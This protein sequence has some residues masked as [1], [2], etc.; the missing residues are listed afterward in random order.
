[1]P[2][3]RAGF[4]RA[5]VAALL[6]LTAFLAAPRSGAAQSLDLDQNGRLDPWA[7]V[8]F[9]F[10]CVEQIS[11]AVPTAYRAQA[12]LRTD[13]VICEQVAAVGSRLDLDGRDGVGGETD[14]YYLARHLLGLP[15]VPPSERATNPGLPSDAA[16]ADA[17]D[18][19]RPGDEPPTATPS[20]TPT[21]TATST[22]TNT[23]TPSASATATETASYTPTRT[24]TPTATRTEVA[25]QTNTATRT[26][27]AT[28]THTG[29]LTPTP[30]PTISRSPTRTATPTR[31]VRPTRTPKNSSGQKSEQKPPAPWLH[32]PGDTQGLEDEDY[33]LEP[34]D[35]P[36]GLTA[37]SLVAGVPCALSE[38]CAVVGGISRLRTTFDSCDLARG[39]VTK[40]V[41]GI[42]TV[43]APGSAL[44]DTGNVPDGIELTRRLQD[45]RS[46]TL[47]GGSAIFEADD[48]MI[49]RTR[50]PEA[51]RSV[52][53]LNGDVAL[54]DSLTGRTTQL[55]FEDFVAVIVAHADGRRS[56]TIDGHVEVDCAGM[57][58]VRT[59]DILQFAAGAA[60][61]TGGEFRVAELAAL[62]EG[63]TS[64]TAGQDPVAAPLEAGTGPVAEYSTGISMQ[65]FRAEG[66]PV[67]QV[68]RFTGGS[69]G[70]DAAR[71]TSLVGSTGAV[72][73]CTDLP[74][75]IRVGALTIG[76]SEL[77]VPLDQ[78]TRSTIINDASP[79]RCFNP[80]AADGDGRL[81]LGPDCVTDSDC[82]CPP[83]GACRTFTLRDGGAMTVGDPVLP[84]GAERIP[85]AVAVQ[86][87]AN[88]TCSG[89][90]GWT[91]AFPFSGNGPTL[92]LDQ[93]DD[94]PEDGFTLALQDS[95]YATGVDGSTVV[96]AYDVGLAQFKAAV[97]ALGI[98]TDD[99]AGTLG[100]SCNRKVL[101]GESDPGAIAAPLVR[102][103]AAGV[104]YDLDDNG[105]D[106]IIPFA[107]LAGLPDGCE[108]DPTPAPEGPCPEPTP[109]GSGT[110]ISRTGT[111]TGGASRVG[112][113]KCGDGGR[114]APE[115]TFTY[116]PP[117]TGFYEINTTGSSFDTILSVRHGGCR[118]SEIACSDDRV[119][120]ALQS[121]IS[122][123]LEAGRTYT[124]IVDGYGE[125]EGNVVLNVRSLAA[126]PT[127]I[128]TPTA[129]P[130]L[131]DLI[132]ASANVSPEPAQLGNAVTTTVTVHNIGGS[133][134]GPSVAVVVLRNAGFGLELSG[135]CGLAAIP[136]GGTASCSVAFGVPPGAPVGAYQFEVTADGFAEVGESNEANNILGR[137][138]GVQPAPGA[139]VPTPVCPSAVLSESAVSG[140]TVGQ[141]N[142]VGGAS[143]GGFGNGGSF[144]P[145]RSFQYTAPAG[146]EYTFDTLGSAFD[147]LLYVREACAGAD[148]VCSDD[149][150]APGGGYVAQSQVTLT[151]QAGQTVVVVV[152]GYGGSQGNFTLNVRA[153]LRSACT[154]DCDGDGEVEGFEYGICQQI[155][156]LIPPGL[157]ASACPS[158]DA[159]GDGGVS[160]AEASEALQN[161]EGGCP[162][163][164]PVVMLDSPL[165]VDTSGLAGAE[166]DNLRAS[167]R[168]FGRPVIRF[169]DVSAAG[170]RAALAGRKALLIPEL[171]FGNLAAALSADALTV[172]RDF[173]RAGG[174][175]LVHGSSPGGVELLNLILGD[176]LGQPI[177]HV[178]A[179][180]FSDRLPAAAQT[181]CS[182]AP[183]SSPLPIFSNNATTALQDLPGNGRAL[184]GG[185]EAATVALIPYGGGQVGFLGWDWYDAAPVGSQDGGWLEVLGC[186][187]DE[188]TS[189]APIAIFDDGRFV[190]SSDTVGAE[191][192]NLQRSLADRGWRAS[193][194]TGIS[195]AQLQ[196]GLAGRQVL[197]IPELEQPTGNLDVELTE[198]AAQVLRDFI[199][200]GGGLI[201]HGY[202]QPRASRLLNRLFPWAV[203]EIAEYA[204]TQRTADGAALCPSP[205]GP[206][207]L[208]RND[209]TGYLATTSLPDGA[210]SLY[211]AS[212]PSGSVASVA[213]MPYGDGRVAFVGWDWFAAAPVGEQD[214][215][216]R[217][218]MDCVLR[219]VGPDQA[220]CADETLALPSSTAGS[221]AGRPDA[222]QG[223]FGYGA[224]DVTYRFTAPESGI[225]EFDTFGS[226]FD[227][228]L[229]IRSVCG[230]PFDYCNDDAG[231]T[232]QSRI[233]VH[234]DD[235]ESVFVTLDGFA[236]YSSGDFVLNV[237]S[238][239]AAPAD[240]TVSYLSLGSGVVTQG[241]PTGGSV[242]TFNVG[243]GNAG[244]STTRVYLSVDAVV[245]AG[246]LLL[247]SCA[248]DPL[249]SYA[250][251]EPCY[252]TSPSINVPAG[253]YTILAVADALHQVGEGANEGNNVRL[254]D[255]GTLTVVAPGTSPDLAIDSLV[256]VNQAAEGQSIPVNAQFSNIGAAPAFGF[257]FDLY[258][259]LDDQIDFSDTFVGYC[260]IAVQAPLTSGTCNTVVSV[261]VPPGTYYL[262]GYVDGTD[263]V[264]ES[265]E[266][267]NI[268]PA[269]TGPITILPSI[270][271]ATVQIG[272]VGATLNSSVFVPV[273]LSTAG[274]TVVGTQVSLPA[275]P[276]TGVQIATVG[277]APDCTVNPAIDKPNSGFV[278]QPPGCT[279][280]VSCD[281]VLAVVIDFSL[282]FTPIADGATLFTC[283]YTVGPSV[284]SGSVPLTCSNAGNSDPEGNS[285]PTECVDGSILITAGSPVIQV[286]T[287]SAF[288]GSQVAVPATLATNGSSVAALQVDIIYPGSAPPVVASGNRPA[289]TVNPAIGKDATSFDFRP[290]GC[291]PGVSCTTIRA[292]VLSFS[293]TTPIPDGAQL[294]SCTFAVGTGVTGSLPL[295]CSLP[296]AVNPDGEALSTSCTSGSITANSVPAT[297]TPVFTFTPTP[298]QSRT[299]TVTP[300]SGAVSSP[301]RTPSRRCCV[302]ACPGGG[303]CL[304]DTTL[305][306]STECQVFCDNRCG[307]TGS[308]SAFGVIGD[309][310]ASGDPPPAFTGTGCGGFLLPT[311]TVTVTPTGTASRTP[312]NTRTPSA[313]ATVTR[314]VTV[315]STVTRTPT[316]TATSVGPLPTPTN[317]S[318]TPSRTPT[319]THTPTFRCC[320]CQCP[321]SSGFCVDNMPSATLCQ[322]AC[323]SAC[324][325]NVFT[326][327]PKVSMCAPSCGGFVFPTATAT[328]QIPTPTRTATRT[329]TPAGG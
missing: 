177:A 143:C 135:S 202:A 311:A 149:A 78:V 306:S 255:T 219:A 84:G 192:D 92:A 131:P 223:C 233:Q 24:L 272:A 11:P 77:P 187:L 312:S 69:G 196:S 20:D 292:I 230:A 82:A 224:P 264:P 51:G 3:P 12:E 44:C 25:T 268:T 100:T 252:F 94:V 61:P 221:T 243:E 159:D 67:Y 163:G 122:T 48:L 154:G 300:P 248:V 64:L 301:T 89:V 96:V 109:L 133:S 288:S 276:L 275:R 195:A 46:E 72:R 85:G 101:Y 36:S 123:Q 322:N 118:A 279:P 172:L 247:A 281:T 317:T 27:A 1:M 283:R 4:A 199:D 214:G 318:L 267:N 326:Y 9:A 18:Q 60:L 319:R 254:A 74:P 108:A 53:R 284:G 162:V 266:S 126:T 35:T 314:T 129:P 19:L 42:M 245:D 294:F 68:I 208:P 128:P 91:Y 217:S 216:W 237:R 52:L 298:T 145:D 329:P 26:V 209:G 23:R 107:A 86:L 80:N 47:I 164:E 193:P 102:Y 253:T 81:C 136:S 222:V 97:G 297:F 239:A 271:T 41:T 315:T 150:L 259:S 79:V 261:W 204:E 201:V 140:T 260:T 170:L 134:A 308:A 141:A 299:P 116:S 262:L 124:I 50:G 28:F 295:F 115:L 200:D 211:T 213:L 194:I 156:G 29:T 190:D 120:G 256:T 184:F 236:S 289:C 127:P 161:A 320:A 183:V 15:A 49:G 153:P 132:I 155:A 2:R 137:G 148:L 309:T 45:Y 327:A 121:E 302:C 7:D 90:P 40:R 182:R 220:A 186:V 228:T 244:A 304:D 280:G 250:F 146:G 16:I 307:M 251:D 71:I 34:F 305:A 22:S 87:A 231:G 62:P 249:A 65:L 263:S 225:Y 241:S 229:S 181:L 313:T 14:V 5:G 215:G 83:G 17:V 178:G 70:V 273:S 226:A 105:L 21:R 111:T 117:T 144:A 171:E 166:A 88:A 66:G 227:T 293:N 174:A 58:D 32:I 63:A 6:M 158:C 57:V 104:G 234:L 33:F 119:L 274:A 59:A 235:G 282:P 114:R 10:R 240:L 287:A 110:M 246:D 310:C 291:T 277:S 76:A 321:D 324:G 258:L 180:V 278:F 37:A 30:S 212:T 139:P 207:V 38:T 98:D 325:S 242:E 13:E 168:S 169:T 103:S 130:S 206:T 54:G 142:S 270:S 147:T 167:L 185:E 152:D 257:F 173:V 55:R 125:A 95:P 265:N 75:A 197:I 73:A 175:L 238:A 138:L 8:V 160:I 93:C 157:P 151:L 188:A 191:A 316:P 210:R 43:S 218:V 165:Y 205:D 198:D 296:E 106:K 286:G 203:S 99:K 323:A 31:T 269:E 113:S 232:V 285:I 39:G 303:F 189:P 328:F 56:M 176:T 112:G 290:F 179:P